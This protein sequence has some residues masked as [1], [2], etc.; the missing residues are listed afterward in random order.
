MANQVTGFTTQTIL[1]R[2]FDAANNRLNVAVDTSVAH[3]WTADQTF[4]DNVKVTLG[5]GGDADLYY[6]GT[7]VILTPDVA[8]SGY[9]NVNGDLIVSDAHGLVVGHTAKVALGS[10]TPEFQVLGTGAPDSSM[11][12]GR[13][14]ADTS[15][16]RLNFVKGR[17]GIG[18]TTTNLSSGDQVME[19]TGRIADVTDNDFNNAVAR[20]TMNVDATPG[21]NDAPGRMSFLTTPD[22]ST[23]LAERLRITSTGQ[24]LIGDTANEDNDAGLTINQGTNTDQCLSLKG[25]DVDHGFDDISELDTYGTMK[26][27]STTNGGLVIEG[28]SLVDRGITFSGHAAAPATDDVD[29]SDAVFHFAASKT[30]GGTG[31]TLLGNDDNLVDFGTGGYCKFLIKGDGDMH[32]KNTTL[33]G[34]DA[35]DDVGLVRLFQREVHNDMGMAISKWDDHIQANK[36]DLIKLGVLSSQGDFRIIQRYEDLLGGAIWQTHERVMAL[37]EQ[38]ATLTLKNAELH[39]MLTEGRN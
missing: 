3:T 4:N 25:S 21:Q 27:Q 33:I 1:N 38:V 7:N 22:G 2:S 23:S 30:N 35:F 9:F 28:F 16:P 13:F 26:R 14:S 37:S 24:V 34:M 32:A 15:G 20:I 12:L 11:S 39:T 18:V 19:I 6:D 17:D 36:E 31:R 8:G 29:G 10:T 5:T